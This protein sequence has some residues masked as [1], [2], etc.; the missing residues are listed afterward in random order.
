MA[1]HGYVSDWS[2]LAPICNSVARWLTIPIRVA[3][4]S[5]LARTELLSSIPPMRDHLPGTSGIRS[6]HSSN[7]RVQVLWPGGSLTLDAERVSMPYLPLNSVSKQRGLTNRPGP[8][9]ALD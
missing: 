9:D 1:V 7:W 2:D 6:R 5:R 8:F 3:G 4:P